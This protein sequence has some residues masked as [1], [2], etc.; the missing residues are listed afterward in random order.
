MDS[1]GQLTV[2]ALTLILRLAGGTGPFVL[3]VSLKYL[4]VGTELETRG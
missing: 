1:V 4:K 2:L 3:S